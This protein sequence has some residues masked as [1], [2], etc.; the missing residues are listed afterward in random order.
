MKK[1]THLYGL[2][3]ALAVTSMAVAILSGQVITDT[4]I[5]TGGKP[6]LAV[7]DFRGS[8]AAQPFMPVFNKTLYADLEGSGLFDMK[9]KSFFPPNN[10]Q[11]PGDLRPEDAGA[12]YALKDWAGSPVNAS[13]LVFGYTAAVNGVFV[14]Y[15]NVYDTRQ[16]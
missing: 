11:Q 14:L 2:F 16:T 7:P 9:S 12:G 3:T 10:P 5:G 8:G 4:I 13:H 15:G 1:S 6:A